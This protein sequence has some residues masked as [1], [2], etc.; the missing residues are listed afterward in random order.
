MVVA[1]EC[2]DASGSGTMKIDPRDSNAKKPHALHL[3]RWQDVGRS[4][5]GGNG[6]TNF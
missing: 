6:S 1:G 5:R 3:V 2:F 4:T